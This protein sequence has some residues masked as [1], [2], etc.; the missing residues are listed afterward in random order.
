MTSLLQDVAERGERIYRE[1]YQTDYE[2]SRPGMYVVIDVDGGQSFVSDT[3]ESALREAMSA[4]PDGRFHLIR[5]GASAVFK[6]GYSR[7]GASRGDRAPG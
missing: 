6:V 7:C 4:R 1:R 5:V 3:P 2:K